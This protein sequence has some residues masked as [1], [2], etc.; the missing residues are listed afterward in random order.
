MA[1]RF[2]LT[3]EYVDGSTQQVTADQR[4]IVRFERDQRI[5]SVQALDMMPLALSWCMAY[6]ALVR[7][8]VVDGVTR[9]EW[10][11]TVVG[12][13]TVELAAADPTQRAARTGSPR[14][15]QRSPASRTRK[16]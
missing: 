16:S 2:E 1:A 6:Y 11:A 5:S 3:V 9:D 15:S 8:G 12:I 13:E 10:E 14:G 4:D 7:T